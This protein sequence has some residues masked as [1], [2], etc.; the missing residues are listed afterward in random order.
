[1][2][3]LQG[4]KCQM[5]ELRLCSR[6]SRSPPGVPGQSTETAVLEIIQQASSGLRWMGDRDRKWGARSIIL[7]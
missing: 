1:M 3:P 6:S 4:S 5:E 7:W 2:T